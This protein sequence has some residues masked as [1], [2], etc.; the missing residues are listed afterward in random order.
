MFN[1]REDE[2]PRPVTLP[3]VVLRTLDDDDVK[4][5]FA[6]QRIIRTGID[7]WQAITQ[8]ETFESWKSIG[9]ALKIGHDYALRATGANAPM[10]R[11]YCEIFSEWIAKSILRKCRNPLAQWRSN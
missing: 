10:G 9:A 5:R 4:D 2:Q 11:P 6:E 1:L 7:A 8:T 3:K